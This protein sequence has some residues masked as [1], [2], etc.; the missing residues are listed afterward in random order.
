MEKEK[1]KSKIHHPK[2]DHDADHEADK[3]KDERY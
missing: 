3:D 1:K 2:S